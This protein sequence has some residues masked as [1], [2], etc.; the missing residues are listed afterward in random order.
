MSDFNFRV[1]QT[2][3]VKLSRPNLER[4]LLHYNLLSQKKA[5]TIEAVVVLK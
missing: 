2:G 3:K 1:F 5:I 4:N